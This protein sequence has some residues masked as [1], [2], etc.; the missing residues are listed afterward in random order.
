MKLKT[1]IIFSIHLISIN[2]SIA[3]T[4]PCASKSAG[5]Q[6]Y[7]DGTTPLGT[8]KCVCAWTCQA[9]NPPSNSCVGASSNACNIPK[10]DSNYTVQNPNPSYN[11]NN[12]SD[13]KICKPATTVCE[14]TCKSDCK[15]C[16]G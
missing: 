13:P 12:N 16:I 11:Y 3:C 14:A 5:L 10:D 7:Y 2:L 8:F 1:L 15:H 9:W 4:D 6:S